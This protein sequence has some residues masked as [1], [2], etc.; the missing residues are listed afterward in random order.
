MVGL[1][2]Y[3]NRNPQP[4]L[5]LPTDPF[6]STGIRGGRCRCGCLSLMLAATGV[7]YGEAG[8]SGL[9]KSLGLDFFGFGVLS[10]DEMLQWEERMR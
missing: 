8:E 4:A 2:D 10:T 9:E 3:P 7:V 6:C 5:S 1:A